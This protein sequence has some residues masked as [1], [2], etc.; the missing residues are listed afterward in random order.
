MVSNQENIII[1]ENLIKEYEVKINELSKVLRSLKL[2]DDIEDRGVPAY[3]VTA[4]NNV[5]LK[6]EQT[7]TKEY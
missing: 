1:I 4:T 6:W 5:P 7:D 3:T 2:E